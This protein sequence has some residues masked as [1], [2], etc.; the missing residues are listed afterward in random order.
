MG[1]TSDDAGREHFTL[2]LRPF[3]DPQNRRHL[4]KTSASP[5]GLPDQLTDPIGQPWTQ[6]NLGLV[7]NLLDTDLRRA[8]A[9][10]IVGAPGL[11]GTP[12]EYGE[13]FQLTPSAAFAAAA[14]AVASGELPPLVAPVAAPAP[15]PV[16]VGAAT[17]INNTPPTVTA[18]KRR[19]VE[20]SPVQAT[21]QEVEPE[22]PF[23]PEP[24]VAGGPPPPPGKPPARLPTA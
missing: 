19:V 18:R 22:L 9:E 21:T 2:F 8:L 1:K 10:E 15:R 7:F 11:A 13:T 24:V 23:V 14:A 6:A 4:L 5:T 3:T 20:T 12:T 16:V 17:P